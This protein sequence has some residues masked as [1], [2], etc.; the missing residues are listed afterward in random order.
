VVLLV[1]VVPVV[2]DVVEVTVV[3]LPPPEQ[4]KLPSHVSPEQQSVSLWQPCPSMTHAAQTVV[5]ESQRSPWPWQQS[6]LTLHDCPSLAQLPVVPLVE[7]FEPMSQ[8]P[9]PLQTKEQQSE[10]VLQVS[11]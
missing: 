10:L 2:D 8:K 7:E 3:V 1:P 11:P 4:R 9:L 5:C 6:E